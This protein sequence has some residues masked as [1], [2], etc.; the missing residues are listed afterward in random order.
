MNAEY[1]LI[2]IVRAKGYLVGMKAGEGADNLIG[3]RCSR[4]HV[5]HKLHAAS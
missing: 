4:Q 1:S 3:D 5:L 2:N